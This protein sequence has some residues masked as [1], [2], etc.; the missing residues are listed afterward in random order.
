MALDRRNETV[1]DRRRC[2]SI[3]GK[4]G[5]AHHLPLNDAACYTGYAIAQPGTEERNAV[6]LQEKCDIGLRRGGE[7]RRDMRLHEGGYGAGI[8]GAGAVYHSRRR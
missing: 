8:S 6:L 5:E 7:A 2:R 1:G 3:D 4:E